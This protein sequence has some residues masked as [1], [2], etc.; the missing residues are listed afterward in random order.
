MR[1]GRA[2]GIVLIGLSIPLLVAAGDEPPHFVPLDDP[3]PQL[4]RRFPELRLEGVPLE[5]A[6]QELSD[7]ARA[8]VVVRWSSLAAAGVGRTTPVTVH[9]YD[10]PLHRALTLVLDAARGPVQLDY[11]IR[12]NVIV[13][14]TADETPDRMLT[15]L[16]DVRD[17]VQKQV[18]W[19][20]RAAPSVR[21]PAGVQLSQ[22]PPPSPR[23]Q[24]VEDLVGTIE[25]SVS[26]ESWKDN[27][28]PIGSIRSFA[29]VLV[30]TN[31]VEAQA[32]VERFLEALRQST[33][34]PVPRNVPTTHPSR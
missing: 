31:S 20:E 10:V 17:L 24:A 5:K 21:V 2:L 11:A 7:G 9:A 1:Y 18:E 22:P 34:A 3:F 19:T 16:Y 28:G 32:G 30:V 8:N 27:G 29:G 23:E 13:V 25:D 33:R 4:L 6:L 15:R 26:R 12:G 14:S